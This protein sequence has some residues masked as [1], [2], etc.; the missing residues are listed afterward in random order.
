ME[1]LKIALLFLGSF[2]VGMLTWGLIHDGLSATPNRVDTIHLAAGEGEM[3]FTWS[4][5]FN[6]GEDIPKLTIRTYTD[7][8]WGIVIQVTPKAFKLTPE[9]LDTDKWPYQG[10]IQVLLNG[11]II[12][13]VYD[14][15][16]YLSAGQL[17]QWMNV[18]ALTLM[19][20]LHKQLIRSD[21]SPIT[22]KIF[23]TLP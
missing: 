17:N 2:L 21:G 14:S 8:Q 5:Q 12:W 16:F 20:T 4:Y 18:I 22:E 1:G 10:Y 3:I 23:V 9:T 6:K 11:K 13:R 15:R 19:T 7:A